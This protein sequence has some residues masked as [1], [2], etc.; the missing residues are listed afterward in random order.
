LA[1]LS[2]QGGGGIAAQLLTRHGVP[3]VVSLR[4]VLAALVML[5][6]RPPQRS[7]AD[8]RA[9]RYA[10]ALGVAMAAMNSLFYLSITRIP[11]GVA[12]TIEFCGPLA[13]AI[14]GSRH[15][16]DVVW[17]A[18]AGLGIYLLAG[19]RLSADDALGVAAAFGAGACW[20]AF[21]VLG[22]RL[23]RSWPD[24]RGLTVSLA[25]ASLIVLPIAIVGGAVGSIL[26]DPAVL[27]GGVALAALSS[28]SPYTLELSA[29]RRMASATYGVLMSLE[30][31]VA[32]IVGFVILSQVPAPLDIV[33][34]SLVGIA[35]AGASL[36]ARRLAVAPGELEAA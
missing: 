23:A 28:V 22:G 20:A 14:L 9:W 2:V 5:I 24:G 1:A 8:A 13:V 31:A 16:R 10:I 17:T 11:L 35:S 18:L 32:A 4:I 12:V 15:V 7:R 6:W 36:T 30:P 19:S 27:L 34:I 21:I 29:M 33:A 26:A 3:L 25:T